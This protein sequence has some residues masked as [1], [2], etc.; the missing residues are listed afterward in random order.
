M[1]ETGKAIKG[2]VMSKLY[3]RAGTEILKRTAFN[4]VLA[5]VSMPLS[6]YNTTGQP[7]FLF[8]LPAMGLALM[9]MNIGMLVDNQW[10]QGQVSTALV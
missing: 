2:W 4:A 6:I 1:L 5:A 3:S 8:C 10:I 7:K 9:R